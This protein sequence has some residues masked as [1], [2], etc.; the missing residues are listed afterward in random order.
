M[1]KRGRGSAR[2]ALGRSGNRETVEGKENK[3]IDI[4]ERLPGIAINV[5]RHC[6]PICSLVSTRLSTRSYSC[7]STS[8]ASASSFP[9][10]AFAFSTIA[11]RCLSRS[12][13][14]C[15]RASVASAESYVFTSA[16]F[17][18]EQR[19]SRYPLSPSRLEATQHD[20]FPL[21]LSPCPV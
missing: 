14:H 3:S 8:D 1:E 15:L 16:S 7:F 17:P 20:P 6:P 18:S 12:S 11:S 5:Q 19:S 9:S 4:F 2:C 10:R 13:T 21:M